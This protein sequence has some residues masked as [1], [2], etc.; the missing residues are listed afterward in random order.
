VIVETVERI[1]EHHPYEMEFVREV[2]P[3]GAEREVPEKM[4]V[5]QLGTVERVVSVAQAGDACAPL[6][7]PEPR[8]G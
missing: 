3:T 2:R 4:T 1:V 7:E 8:Q 5:E 6:K